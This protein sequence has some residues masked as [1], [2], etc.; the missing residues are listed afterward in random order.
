MKRITE[1]LI[2]PGQVG[3]EM[4]SGDGVVRRVHPIFATYVGDH[5]EQLLV[6]GMKM[7]NV[8]F[9]LCHMMSLETI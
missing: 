8:P 9:V 4:S 6:T 2:Q 3:L 7:A 5:P 1:P